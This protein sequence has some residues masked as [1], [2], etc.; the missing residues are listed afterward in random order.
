MFNPTYPRRADFKHGINRVFMSS[1]YIYIKK[2]ILPRH[3]SKM[4]NTPVSFSLCSSV[5]SSDFTYTFY[6]YF[7]C[8]KSVFSK[9]VDHSRGQVVNVMMRLLQNRFWPA[10][11]RIEV[12][13]DVIVLL[14]IIQ[15]CLCVKIFIFYNQLIIE[16]HKKKK[17]ARL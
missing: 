7:S 17:R 5:R 1:L 3:F 2:K 13:F 10:V 8:E 12:T 4:S 15:A 16:F 6:L 9:K 11:E 14:I